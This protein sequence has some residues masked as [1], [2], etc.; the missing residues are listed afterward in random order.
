MEARSAIRLF[1]QLILLLFLIDPVVGLERAPDFALVDINGN[2]FRLLNQLGK[3]VLID[4]FAT[5]CGPCVS[6][7][8]H[9]KAIYDEYPEDKLVII[10]ISV[11]PQDANDDL[12][13][14]AQQHGVVWTVARDTDLV[15][16][17]YGVSPIPQLSIIDDEG[18]KRYEHVGL[19]PES[20][21]VSEIDSL[22][23]NGGNESSEEPPWGIYT[24][25]LMV[26]VIIVGAIVLRKPWKSSRTR[27][28]RK[29]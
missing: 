16:S 10:S 24:A 20:K 14:F 19:T 29:R 15:S 9:L 8:E 5:W 6:E 26:A 18:Y 4:F 28:G 25:M 17:K 1:L 3:V 13:D 22:L 2:H 11:D 23:S 7:I 21:L 12:R 27:H